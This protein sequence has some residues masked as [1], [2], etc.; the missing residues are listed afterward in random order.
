GGGVFQ[1]DVGYPIEKPIGKENE[2]F[3]A[4]SQGSGNAVSAHARGELV[5]SLF[6]HGHV[7]DLLRQGGFPDAN[8]DVR[9]FLLGL[10]ILAVADK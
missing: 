8:I 4:S 7:R 10:N 1:I 2:P 6:F 5:G 9:G 3:E